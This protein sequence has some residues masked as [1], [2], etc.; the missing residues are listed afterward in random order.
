VNPPIICQV[1]NRAL[2]SYT[3]L[4]GVTW[5]HTYGHIAEGVDHDP[6]PVEAPPGW[7]GLCD[8]CSDQ[9]PVFRVPARDFRLPGQPMHMS[10]DDWA[11]CRV[12]G[13]LIDSNR[14]TN[15]AQRAATTWE[16][17]HGKPLDDTAKTRLRALYRVLR[18]NI[19][20][21]LRPLGDQT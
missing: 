8:F 1:C 10:H 6:E 5:Q 7:R 3:D 21:S 9:E 15:L 19:T 2:D 14:W 16:D 13:L 4:S 18:K 17:H 11:A 20:G 12:C